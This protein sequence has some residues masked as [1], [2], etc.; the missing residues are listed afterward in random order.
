MK[1]PANNLPENPLRN[2]K[3]KEFF[4]EQLN[5]IYCIKSHLQERLPEIRQNAHFADL[6][7][8]I[9]QTL[10]DVEKQISHMDEIYVMLEIKYN[11]ENCRGI[12]S[13]IEDM[14]TVICREGAD[15][16]MR[17][18]SVLVYLQNIEHME[19][20]SFHMLKMAAEKLNQKQIIKLLQQSFEEAKENL[21]LLQLI[22]LNYF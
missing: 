18:L 12:I 3:L 20:A 8:G 4:T 16:E 22:T 17:D 21:G 1:E 2:K 19:M 5:R 11:F 13:M 14:F 6:Y 10:A 7:D 15:P 9:T